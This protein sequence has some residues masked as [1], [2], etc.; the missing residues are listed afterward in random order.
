MSRLIYV[1]TLLT[2]LPGSFFLTLWLLG[3]A[4]DDN[5]ASADPG[6]MASGSLATGSQIIP[7]CALQQETPD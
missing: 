7:T 2:V 5:L 1:G 4:T 3:D 6:P